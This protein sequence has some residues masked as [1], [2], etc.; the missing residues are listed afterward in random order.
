MPR[1]RRL[2][3]VWIPVKFV[4]FIFCPFVRTDAQ[5]VCFRA[6]VASDDCK[7]RRL[8]GVLFSHGLSRIRIAQ[9]T[10]DG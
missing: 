4:Q 1:D 3:Y 5:E 8:W 7:L 9:R 10:D 6:Q 2:E